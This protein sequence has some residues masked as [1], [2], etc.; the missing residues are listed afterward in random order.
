MLQARFAI[1][2]D[3][4]YT[5]ITYV[6]KTPGFTARIGKAQYTFEWQNALGVGGR[7]G[8]V[9]VEHA[10]KL[11]RWRDRRGKCLFTLE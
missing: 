3:I 11:S 2:M 9:P 4:R 10:K 1:K 8:E 6:G 7:R 5:A